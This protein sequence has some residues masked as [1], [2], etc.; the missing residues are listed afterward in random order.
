MPQMKGVIAE[1]L[2][3]PCANDAGLRENMSQTVTK[4]ECYHWLKADKSALY[5][6]IYL[7][8]MAMS[9]SFCEAFMVF[10]FKKTQH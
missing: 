10:L 4:V 3:A 9:S 5:T 8:C 2:D 7:L 1:V 6:F